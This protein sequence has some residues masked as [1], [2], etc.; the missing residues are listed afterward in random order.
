[1]SFYIGQRVRLRYVRESLHPAWFAGAEGMIAA[2]NHPVADFNGYVY[3]WH[4]ITDGGAHGVPIEDQLE[5][6]LPPG[7]ESLEEINALYE[8]IEVH[9]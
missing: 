9:A 3:H 1:M 2:R 5:P 8:P 4:V 7:L 6:I